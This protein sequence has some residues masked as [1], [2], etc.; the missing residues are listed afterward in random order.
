[1]G[2]I[3]PAAKGT[4]KEHLRIRDILAHQSGLPAW[5]PF[6]VKTLKNNQP[7]PAVYA[8]SKDENHT[9][10]VSENLFMRNDYVGTMYSDIWSAPL[11]SKDYKY[12]DV[13][14]YFFKA[15]T[16][17]YFKKPLDQMG[18]D[19][20]FGPLGAYSLTFNPL[21]KFDKTIIPPTEQDKYFRY[22]AIQGYVHDQGAAMMGGVAG[23]AGLFGSASDLAKLMQ[24]YLQFGEYGG[25]RFL[26]SSTVAEFIRCQFCDKN[27]RRGAGFDKPQ[28]SGS[29]PTCNCVSMLSFGHTGFTGTMAWS[30]PAEKIVYIFLSNRTWP[31]AENRKLIKMDT[32]AK[33]Q[34][35][36]YNSLNTYKI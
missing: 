1:L 18:E 14:Y 33:I 32:R 19:L 15:I 21:K 23:H 35:V 2:S 17:E 29:G 30:D 6:Y 13:G 26:D 9:L 10:Q 7:D 20:F 4:N 25:T 16:E 22:D 3:Y 27:N 11:G 36:I 12:S 5:I 8:T 31:D 34:E 28:F 24:M